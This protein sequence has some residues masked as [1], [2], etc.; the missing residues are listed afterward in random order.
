MACPVPRCS[1]ES[2]H[3]GNVTG[4]PCDVGG[5]NLRRPAALYP[6]ALSRHPIGLIPYFMTTAVAQQ[7]EP[8]ETRVTSGRRRA[9]A[10]LERWHRASLIV[11]LGITVV[12]GIGLA[13]HYGSTLHYYDEHSY[14]KIARNLAD[15][16]RFSLNGV[17]PTAFRDPGW[18]LL[19]GV[20]NFFGGDVFVFRLANVALEACSITGVWWLA[21]RIG[22][23]A[24]GTLAA[25]ALAL[26]PLSV[27]TTSTLY[28]E[29]MGT[30]L[31]I[32]GLICTVKV[33]ES[34]H[35]LRWSI[36]GGAVFGLLILTVAD[37]AIGLVGAALWLIFG[38]TNFRKAALVMV[39]VAVAV[40]AVWLVRNEASM[41]AF[42]PI[43]DN[44]GYNL[45]LANSAHAS[46]RAGVNANIDQYLARAPVHNEVGL[47]NSLR[48][49]SL[50]WIGTHPGLA[51]TRYAERVGDYFAPFDALATSAQS[52]N[53]KNA[54]A[55]VTYLPL[56]CLFVVRLVLWRR[57]R[58]GDLEKLLIWLYVGF[59]F[60]EAIFLSRVRYRVPLDALLIVVVASMVTWPP[61]PSFR[62]AP[63]VADA[64]V[65][66][67]PET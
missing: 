59:A 37:L 25:P 60:L 22:G 48:A 51:A 47:D 64:P 18:P 58:P 28:P 3:D 55:A 13:V 44:N 41:H 33:R 6:L 17:Q 39:A 35:R 36:L 32:G 1:V 12:L 23:Q 45:I 7:P 10:H 66:H 16:G 8:T 19:L 29:T 50:H 61:R 53:A 2:E 11:S 5:G 26:Y 4:P 46:I 62:A 54:L 31:L 52:S 15:H 67:A 21:T 49:Q 14:V 40:M 24:A 20:L 63:A 27:Y 42:I 65:V 34:P 9:I 43:G 56:L 30:A 57:R 38:H